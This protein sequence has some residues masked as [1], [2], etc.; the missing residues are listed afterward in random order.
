VLGERIERK[1]YELL[2]TI[3]LALDRYVQVGGRRAS[4][5]AR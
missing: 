1:L 5:L 2:E 4:A 3:P